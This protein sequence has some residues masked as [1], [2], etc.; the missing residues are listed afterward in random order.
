MTEMV[1]VGCRLPAGVNLPALKKGGD[2]VSL[3]GSYRHRSFNE[4]TGL[5][6]PWA[7]G[8]TQVDAD[9][10]EAFKAQYAD[11]Q[12]LKS[13]VIFEA[14]TAKAA[15]SEARERQDEKTGFERIDPDALAKDKL[16][17]ID[18]ATKKPIKRAA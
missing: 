2:I 6:A 11:W 12:P 17:Q 15:E 10:W 5:I 18:P 3:N 14:K 13:G 7:Y 4:A 16:Q 8:V 1:T 9:Y